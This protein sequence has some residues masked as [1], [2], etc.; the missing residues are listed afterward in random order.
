MI[1]SLPI[2]VVDDDESLR[3]AIVEIISDE[4]IPC[5]QA[6]SAEAAEKMLASTP[7]AMIISDMQMGGKSGQ[8]LLESASR[9]WPHVPV[10]LMTAYAKVEDAT[11]A[12]R[13]GA[14]EYIEKPFDADKLVALIKKYLPQTSNTDGRIA[15]SPAMRHTL[16]IAEKV[17]TYPATVMLTGESG[18]G[19]E[20]LARHIHQK[21][22]RAKGP[23][24]ALNCS[25]IPA[26]LLESILFG[27]SK[28]AFTGAGKNHVGKIQQADGGT[29]FLDEIGEMPAELQAKILRVLQEREIE[30]IGASQSVKIDV[31]FIAATHRNLTEAIAEGT[32]RS[33]LFYRLNVFPIEV[34]ALRERSEDIL[35]LAKAFLIKYGP[36]Y[37]K[38]GVQLTPRAEMALLQ[39]P[40]PGNVRELENTIQRALILSSDAIDKEHLGLPS[41][42]VSTNETIKS[43]K[44]IER[45]AISAAINA[46]NGDTQAAAKLLDISHKSLVNKIRQNPKE[47]G[48]QS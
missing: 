16:S 47:E 12:I 19:K 3:A 13:S 31:R 48:M 7:Y 41:P 28:G 44:E 21:S 1:S 27:H 33:D 6:N 2:L 29:L 4:S 39:Y 36:P 43:L 25:A 15:N 10:V 34:P 35:D 5:A 40:W 46:T 42:K 26:D 22:P 8:D 18:S 45:A 32:F 37:G 38:K 24:V 9:L 23:F 30:P 11:K 14:V 17:A 20:V